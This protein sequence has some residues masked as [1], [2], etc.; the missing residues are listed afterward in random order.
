MNSCCGGSCGVNMKSVG[1]NKLRRWR[2]VLP[3]KGLINWGAELTVIVYILQKWSP[4]V[5]GALSVVINLCF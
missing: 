3:K 2:K 4:A 1:F 5:A